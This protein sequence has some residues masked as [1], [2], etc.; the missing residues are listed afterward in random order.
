[1]ST[2][3]QLTP[4]DPLPGLVEAKTIRK[5]A[6]S[7]QPMNFLRPLMTQPSPSRTATVR[8]AEMSEPVSGS[9]KA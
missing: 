7:T 9:V 1:L 8:I 6:K 2:R 3:K 5:S 4:R